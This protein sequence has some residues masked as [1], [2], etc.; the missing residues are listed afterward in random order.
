MDSSPMQRIVARQ[1]IEDVVIGYCRGID[2]LDEELIRATFF[3][4][5]VDDHGAHYKGNAWAHVDRIMKV[6]PQFC[7]ASLHTLGN[8]MVE[9][10][11]DEVAYVESHIVAWHRIDRDG[12]TY[13]YTLYGRYVDRFEKRNGRWLVAYRLLIE[14]GRRIDK[15]TLDS[16]DDWPDPAGRTYGERSRRDPVYARP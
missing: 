9:F 16:F 14:D 6:M 12:D 2:R 15:L 7:R 5:A 10:A 1:E 3:E 4:D 8:I 11:G 13:D